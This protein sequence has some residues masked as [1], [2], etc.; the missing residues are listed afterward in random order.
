MRHVKGGS[1]QEQGIWIVVEC[2][3]TLYLKENT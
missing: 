1:K 2:E 3:D